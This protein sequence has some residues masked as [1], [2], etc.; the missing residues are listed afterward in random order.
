LS[1]EDWILAA[2]RAMSDQ[3]V[4]GIAVEP[5]AKSLGA[6][7]GSF[8]WHFRD[9]ADLV[10]AALERW[11][12][13]GTEAV[14]AT[15]SPVV[16]GRARLRQLFEAL[17]ITQKP[18]SADHSL[19]IRSG[20]KALDLSI[21]LTADRETPVVAELIDRVTT[22]RVAYIAEQLCDLGIEPGEARRRA[23]FA[24]TAYI[25]FA[26]LAR[27]TSDTVPHGSEAQNFVDSMLRILTVD[28]DT[29]ADR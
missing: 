27:G 29:Q 19:T 6:T 8:Y 12:R 28:T 14:I 11:E 15:L 24:Y 2:L 9:R 23:L 16:D 3:G 13:E 25:G 7:K 1:R 10:M 18:D 4:S 5:L 20:G 21:A 22:R 26:R 17:F